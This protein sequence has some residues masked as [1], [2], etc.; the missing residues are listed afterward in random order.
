MGAN[1]SLSRPGNH[2]LLDFKLCIVGVDLD[3]LGLPPSLAAMDS[4][5]SLASQGLAFIT[6]SFDPDQISP[7]SKTLSETI[8]LDCD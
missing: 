3:E 2:T 5:I 1:I 8:N 4:P 7:I 6:C